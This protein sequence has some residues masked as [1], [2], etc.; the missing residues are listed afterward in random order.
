[1]RFKSILGALIFVCFATLFATVSFI[2]T[3]NFGR[4]ATKVISDLSQKKANTQVSVKHFSISLFP[5][6]IELNQVKV[7]K[8]FGEGKKFESEFG[9]LGLY[10]GL[11][12]FE[13]K[14][15]S[16]GEIKISDSIVKYTSPESD[17]EIKEIDQEI[18]NEVFRLSDRLPL[19]IDTVILQNAKIHLN[20]E[21]LEAKRVKVFKRAD[22][23]MVR[24]HLANLRPLRE[25]DFSLDEIWGDAEI[26]RKNIN[27]HR[28]KVQHDVHSLLIK[29]KIKNYPLLK[30]SELSLSGESSVFLKNM[31]QEIALPDLIKIDAGF[32]HFSFKLGFAQRKLEGL[33]DLSLAGLDSNVIKADQL[34]TS[35][36]LKNDILSVKSLSLINKKEKLRLV[37]GV[38]VFN[39]K[40]SD[41]LYDPINIQLDQ[42]DL[43]N[44][45]GILPSLHSIKGELT[46]QLKFTYKNK[47]LDFEPKD[48]FVIHH[49]GLVVGEDKPFTVLMI[50]KAVL[51]SASFRVKKLKEFQMD[52]LVQLEHS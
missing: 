52:S 15:I 49:L 8:D 2:Q 36:D 45:L 11:I 5:P 6:G 29:G 51:N 33:L 23:F 21:L 3:K 40:N 28:L 9:K 26:G 44:A 4:I 13:E 50:K 24:F 43:N 7:K 46:G 17:E 16:L 30:N 14:K 37:S 34:I 1:M 22:A 31:S 42:F 32:A 12:E 41:Y 47:D 10:V 39:L 20:H 19:T 27:L 35:V 18:I 25:K 38:D 48:G